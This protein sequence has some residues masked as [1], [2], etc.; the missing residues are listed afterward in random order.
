M[1]PGHPND[2]DRSPNLTMQLKVDNR[3]VNLNVRVEGR[4]PDLVLVHGVGGSLEAWDPVVS[5]LADRYRI[6]RVDLRGHGAS[7]KPAGPYRIDD[8]VSDVIA[9]MDRLEVGAGHIAGHSL[10]ALIAQGLVLARPE[11]VNRLVL[12]SGV[13]GRTDEERRRVEK[14]LAM[15]AD[16]IPGAHFEASVSRWFTDD[17]LI[18]H[19][20]IITRHAEANRR[21]DPAAYA[22]AYRVLASTDFGERLGE[23]AVPTLI[24]TGE[25]DQGS[26]TRMARL[27]HERIPRSTLHILPGLKHAIL[28]EVPDE[29]ARLIR[30]FVG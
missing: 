28:T 23:I 29:V 1:Q 17:Y 20:D 2:A 21:N 4:G 15:V 25:H 22:A 7:D 13:A 27:M 18:S 19:P 3:G 11:R 30:D 8:F 5:C 10:G 16:G 9:V 24:A 6:I 14:R 26:N 12:L